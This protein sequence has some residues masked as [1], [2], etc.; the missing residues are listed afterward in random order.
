MSGAVCDVILTPVGPCA[1]WVRCGRVCR[2]DFSRASGASPQVLPRVRRWMEAFF[3][4]CVPKVPLDLSGATPFQ[5]YVY[6]AARRIPFGGTV[7]YG[8][9]ARMVG[10]RSG[11]ARAVG[12][13]MACNPIPLFVPCHRVVSAVGPGGFSVSG[14]LA[15]K[16]RLLAFERRAVSA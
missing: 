12:R 5:Q 2:V 10:R 9:L 16:H 15:L 1:V 11:A 6:A 4:G 8:Q 14:G 13:A 3:A 7:T